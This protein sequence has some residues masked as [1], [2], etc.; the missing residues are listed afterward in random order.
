MRKRSDATPTPETPK[1]SNLSK[2]K[3]EP[4]QGYPPPDGVSPAK[5]AAAAVAAPAAAAPPKQDNPTI[6]AIP[7]L[8]DN[9]QTIVTSTFGLP[10]PM[11]LYRQVE[12]AIKAIKPSKLS[13]AELLDALDNAQEY[14]RLARQLYVNAKAT[15]ESVELDVQLV[16]SSMRDQA[17]ATLEAEKAEGIRKKQITEADIVALASRSFPDEWK[18][19]HDQ[20]TRGKYTLSYLDSLCERTAERA[21]DLRAIVSASRGV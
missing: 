2:P 21:R 18:A 11:E 1:G 14:A 7:T 8:P 6:P 12:G 19:A 10:D 16:V 5:A 17:L 4:K 13:L 15:V 9:Y 3:D 20:L